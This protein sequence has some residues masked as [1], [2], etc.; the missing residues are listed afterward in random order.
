MIRL[1]LSIS[2]VASCCSLKD[3]LYFEGAKIHCACATRTFENTSGAR[4]WDVWWENELADMESTR[5]Q[6]A[7][8]SR[9]IVFSRGYN[10]ICYRLLDIIVYIIVYSSRL[11]RLRL[12]VLED[13]GLEVVVLWIID[14]I[15]NREP[16]TRY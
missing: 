16:R 13:W 12:E 10:Y 3:K 15:D 7:Q 14:K 6:R 8:P 4:V 1:Y 2:G 11:L 9:Q 5:V